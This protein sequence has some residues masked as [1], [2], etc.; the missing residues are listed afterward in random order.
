HENTVQWRWRWLYVTAQ[1]RL[2]VPSQEPETVLLCD[3]RTGHLIQRLN[4]PAMPPQLRLD[5]C[6]D[7]VPALLPRFGRLILPPEKPEPFIRVAEYGMLVACGRQAWGLRAYRPT[8][9]D[10]GATPRLAPSPMPLR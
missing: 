6:F 10:Q 8:N 1:L 9:S 5:W 2:T 3:P 7:P 4:F